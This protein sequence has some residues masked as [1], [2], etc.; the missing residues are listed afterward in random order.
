MKR[1][2]GSGQDQLR[3][4]HI[5]GGI[6]KAWIDRT[7]YPEFSG[8]LPTGEEVMNRSLRTRWRAY[9]K[10]LRQDFMQATRDDPEL[11]RAFEEELN[12]P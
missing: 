6:V 11:K 1:G 8:R 2:S 12:K 7:G 10:R 3:V 9:L 4:E 5:F